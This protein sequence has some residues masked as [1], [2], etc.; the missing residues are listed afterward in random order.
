MNEIRQEEYEIQNFVNEVLIPSFPNWT[1]K[2]FGTFKK[3]N[4]KANTFFGEASKTQ[5]FEGTPYQYIGNCQFLH[6]T[7]LISLKAILDCGWLRMSEFGNLSDNT[8]FVYAASSV[9][10][11]ELE[12][13]KVDLDSIKE[14]LFSL[15]ACEVSQ[16]NN[17]D[18]YL[19]NV[20]GDQGKGVSIEYEFS[21]FKVYDYLFGNVRYG[22][23]S[24]DLLKEVF[25]NFNIYKKS[26][27]GI[28]PTNF[29][30]LISDILVFHKAG[31][32]K[33]E[34]E[35]R[36]F[37]RSEK[38]SWEKHEKFLIYKDFNTIQ[39]VRYF[40]KLF[41]KGRNPFFA[42]GDVSDVMKNEILGVIPQVEIKK[43]TLG[44]NISIGKK[45]DI[46]DLLN[47]LK[48]KHNYEYSI[49]HL[50]ADSEIRPFF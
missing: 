23:E 9:F 30:N 33:S 50:N 35:V 11:G 8:E 49:F 42:N 34:K 3:V 28:Y 10:G 37:W 18:P 17:I 31:Q 5:I 47:E 19:W 48:K 1:L 32:F 22:I 29:L 12:F 15:S 27:R 36:L 43:I 25:H 7:S 38:S 39:E 40:A 2:S 46:L 13:S 26:N 21:N 14:T 20:Y 16:E 44:S 41:L 45:L 24:L 4:S 6:F